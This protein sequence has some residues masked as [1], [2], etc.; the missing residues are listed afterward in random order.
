MILKWI[1]SVVETPKNEAIQ[2]GAIEEAK[3]QKESKLIDVA[4]E[5]LREKAAEHRADLDGLVKYGWPHVQREKFKGSV[6]K[7]VWDLVK[8]NIGAEDDEIV[9]EV[10]ERIVDAAEVDPYYQKLF[11]EK[12]SK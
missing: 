2:Q 1:K 4:Q 9:E 12:Q 3:K 10:T 8:R 5:A 11:E 6:R 7:R